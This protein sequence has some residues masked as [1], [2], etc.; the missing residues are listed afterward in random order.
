[1]QG[2][3]TFGCVSPISNVF[4]ITQLSDSIPE[5]PVLNISDTT[6][7]MGN[8]VHLAAPDGYP[9]YEWSSGHTSQEL[10]IIQSGSFSVQVGTNPACLATS[11]P[12]NVNVLLTPEQPFISGNGSLLAS[13]YFSGNQ[14]FLNGVAIEAATDQFHEATI[15]GFYSVQ[16]TLDGCSSA[17]S[18]LYNQ[19]ITPV[20][21]ISKDERVLLYPNPTYGQIKIIQNEYKQIRLEVFDLAGRK[22][23]AKITAEEVD[24][25]DLHAG[26]YVLKISN[27]DASRI[28]TFYISKI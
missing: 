6:V 7:C 19:T 11:E 12:I 28:S 21:E 9:Y 25:S 3:T 24:L 14:W 4:S 20:E 18:E 15:A 13:S 5:T 2:Y 17:P 23:Y 1:M 8:A 27:T 26:N 22:M 16:V 10:E